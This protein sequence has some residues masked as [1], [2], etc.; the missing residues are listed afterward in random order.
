MSAHEGESL[1]HKRLVK[2]LIG[3][4]TRQGFEIINASCEGYK[5]CP[6]IEGQSPD[7]RAYK[8]IQDFIAIGEAKTADQF[9]SEQTGDQF[10]KFSSLVLGSG[11]NKG[12][13]VPFCIALSKGTEAQLAVAL[14]KF[15]LDKKPN[16]YRWPF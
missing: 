12:N 8:R 6:E 11:K 13:K 16:I 4:L 9:F 2:A 7:V 15:G 5:P 3:E 1:E 10:E 14:A